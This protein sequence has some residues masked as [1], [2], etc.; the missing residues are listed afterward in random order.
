MRTCSSESSK[1]AM[2]EAMTRSGRRRFF[3]VASRLERA[4]AG[5]TSPVTFTMAAKA[6]ML[7]SLRLRCFWPRS[8]PAMV[9][10]KPASRNFF[11]ASS[12]DSS[13]LRT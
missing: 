11:A 4:M 3:S 10:T 8:S 2:L 1:S 13:V 6:E 7:P 9:A 12:G 5:S